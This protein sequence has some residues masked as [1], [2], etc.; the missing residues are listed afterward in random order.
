MST[1]TK[2]RVAGIASGEKCYT[3][4]DVVELARSRWHRSKRSR[5]RGKSPVLRA[6]LSEL[7]ANR[8]ITMQLNT[9]SRK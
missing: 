1:I 4:D 9:T 6:N 2:E 5:W 7:A 8:L 3:H